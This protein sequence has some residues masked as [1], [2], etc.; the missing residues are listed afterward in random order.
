MAY[1]ERWC[2]RAAGWISGSARGS[3]YVKAVVWQA[4]VLDKAHVVHDEAVQIIAYEEYSWPCSEPFTGYV[5]HIFLGFIQ[6]TC[7]HHNLK[8]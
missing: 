8:V 4:A 7:C 2:N 6:I 5:I 3:R 1:R